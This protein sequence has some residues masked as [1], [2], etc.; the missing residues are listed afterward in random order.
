M[1][2]RPRHLRRSV[3]T[4]RRTRLHTF[5]FQGQ[6]ED[7]KRGFIIIGTPSFLTAQAILDEIYKSYQNNKLV[8]IKKCPNH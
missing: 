5:P 2:L 3:Q 6:Y 7:G 1:G 8:N 4:E